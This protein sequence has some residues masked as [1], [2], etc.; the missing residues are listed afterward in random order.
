[1]ILSSV[2]PHDTNAVLH[3]DR[4]QQRIV[5]TSHRKHNTLLPQYIEAKQCFWEHSSATQ[6]YHMTRRSHYGSHVQSQA[7][8]C[9]LCD[10]KFT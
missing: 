3:N 7:Y 10:V 9:F 1:M 5:T 8:F 2:V 4:E 6:C